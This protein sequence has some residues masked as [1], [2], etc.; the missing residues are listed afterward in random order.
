MSRP[1]RI[2]PSLHHLQ[3]HAIFLP[4]V[5]STSKI[6]QEEDWELVDNPSLPEHVLGGQKLSKVILRDKDLIVAHGR[7]IRIAS[8]GLDEWELK[9]EHVG[10]YRVYWDSPLLLTMY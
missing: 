7:E 1:E 6:A 9:D 2:P 3:S 4:P 5:T 8:L 10:C